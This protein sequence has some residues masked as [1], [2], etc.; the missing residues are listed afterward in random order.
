MGSPEIGRPGCKS[1]GLNA[2]NGC[3]A[4]WRGFMPRGV[5]GFPIYRPEHWAFAKTGLFYGDVLGEEGHIY[6]YEVDG[7]DYEIRNGLPY[8][9]PTSGAPDGLEILAVGMATH[10]E[11]N[12]DLASGDYVWYGNPSNPN[13]YGNGMIVNFKRGKGEVFHAGTCEW[14]AGLLR[15]DAMVEIVTRNV[16]NRYLG[17][18]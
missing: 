17:R 6:G 10:V 8:P 15:R 3:Y 13:K 5:R 1:F 4:G 18:R 11:E 12:A 14:V 16:L 7:L 9:S 2:S